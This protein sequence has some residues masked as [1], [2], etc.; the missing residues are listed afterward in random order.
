MT[1]KYFL[2]KK[3]WYRN[4]LKRLLSPNRNGKKKVL[5]IGMREPRNRIFGFKWHKARYISKYM[6]PL[7]HV[8]LWLKEFWAILI[9]QE[10]SYGDLCSSYTFSSTPPPSPAPP[11]KKK[12]NKRK[13]GGKRG[14]LKHLALMWQIFRIC[15]SPSRSLTA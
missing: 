9:R 4:L 15:G 6:S 7:R 2:P 5:G 8:R 13:L 10:K 1:F 12:R 14:S 3:R 11:R